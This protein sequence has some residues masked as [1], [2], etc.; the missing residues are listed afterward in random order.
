MPREPNPE[1]APVIQIET[2]P[3]RPEAP[4]LICF[5]PKGIKM[6]RTLVVINGDER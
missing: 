6:N 2:S 1:I 5:A 3:N 4:D